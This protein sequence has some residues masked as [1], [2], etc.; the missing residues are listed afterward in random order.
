MNEVLVVGYGTQKRSN[1]S[2][3]VS[4]ITAEELT[5]TPSLRAE[6]AIQGR[7]AGV[8][9]AQ[10][11]GSPGSALSVR[12]RGVGTISGGDPL[13]I[14]DGVPVSNLDFLSPNDIASLNILKDAASS[15][16][17]GSR[18][19]NGVVLITTKK[20][21]KGQQ[22]R[23]QYDSYYGIQS[24]WK[25]LHLLNAREYALIQNEAY[26]ASGQTPPIEFNN[27]DAFGEGTDWQDAIFQTAPITNHQLTLTGGGEKTSIALTGNY[28]LQD[29]IVGGEKS[30][31]ERVTARLNASHDF[32][33]WLQIGNTLGLTHFKRDAIPENN[34]NS[35]PLIRALNMDPITPVRKFDGTYAYSNYSDTDITNPVNQIEQTFDTWKSNRILA[36]IFSNIKFTEGLSLKTTY[37]ID[38]TFAN[39][40]LFSPEFNLSYDTLLSDAPSQEIRPENFVGYRTYNWSQW[41]LENVLTYGKT[42]KE[43]HDIKAML[44]NTIL[45][46][47]AYDNG[48]GNSNLPSNNPDDAYINNTVDP[49]A[50]QTASESAAE[51][52]LLSYFGRVNYA[53]DEKY[54]FAA[55]FRMDGSSKF[56]VNNRYGYFPSFSA[57]WIVTNESFWDT[58]FVSFMKFRASWGRNGNDNIGDYSYSTVINSGQNYSFSSNEIITNG[59][60]ATKASNPDLK[61]E[62]ITQ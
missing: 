30:R 29:G 55:T 42:V 22:G 21:G 58:D 51:S 19:A 53:F 17:Y 31:F 23:I 24:P 35:S 36:S 59:S 34:Q 15:A 6:Q 37:G 62:T 20:G 49:I 38:V 5:E 11:S 28:F 16:I 54:L 46:N 57:A 4:V 60:V 45:E 1:I 41:Q 27:P 10:N 13:Y 43:K 2:G 48:G 40:D 47:K 12:I 3:S 26:I 9:V 32:K 8:A 56:G 18:G 50:S 44:G 39:Q 25:K 61:W 7:T 33:D 14:V 52:S